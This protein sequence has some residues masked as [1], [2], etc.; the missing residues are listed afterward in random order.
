MN[1]LFQVLSLSDTEGLPIGIAHEATGEISTQISFHPFGWD[2]E[3]EISKEEEKHPEQ[4]ITQKITSCLVHTVKSWGPYDFTEMKPAERQLRIRDSYF[5]DVF[6]AYCKLRMEAIGPEMIVF[7]SCPKCKDNITWEIDLGS[8]DIYQAKSNQVIKKY[9]MSPPIKIGSNECNWIEAAPV[10]W[11]PCYSSP[12][13]TFAT[14]DPRFRRNIFADAIRNAEGIETHGALLMTDERL[15][16]LSKRDI[17]RLQ[18]IIDNNSGG[19]DL[20]SKI[21]CPRCGLEFAIISDWSY[22]HF[23]GSS[24][25]Q[26]L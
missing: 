18:K 9:E 14:S 21:K 5:A 25:L 20:R 8:L 13:D 11:E 3:V 17:E 12:A 1:D 23:F 26:N 4:T 7:A 6:T 22:D 16:T 2:Q 15:R 24:S 10:R 19:P